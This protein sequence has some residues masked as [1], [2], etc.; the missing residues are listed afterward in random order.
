MFEKKFKKVSIKV[1]EDNAKY[2]AEIHKQNKKLKSNVK[3]VEER[4]DRAVEEIVK[5]KDENKVLQQKVDDLEAGQARWDLLD[6]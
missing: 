2:A 5:L 3:T 1:L 6:L 4:Y